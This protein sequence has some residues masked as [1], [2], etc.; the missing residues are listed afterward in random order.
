[1]LI[2]D[3]SSTDDDNSRPNCGGRVEGPRFGK[4]SGNDQISNP[5]PRILKKQKKFSVESNMDK[6]GY[7]QFA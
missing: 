2:V 7:D 5:L 6:I 1:M 3:P 4:T